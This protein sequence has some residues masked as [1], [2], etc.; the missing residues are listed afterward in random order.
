MPR[1]EHAEHTFTAAPESVAAARS[2]TTRTLESWDLT[3]R[4]D[5]IRLCV[6]EL[7]ANAVEH[8]TRRTA[9]GQG[10]FLVRID[11]DD[12]HIRLEVEDDDPLGTPRLNRAQ[13]EDTGGRGMMIV[14]SLATAWGFESCAFAG[15]AVWSE[16]L[17]GPTADRQDTHRCADHCHRR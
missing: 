15:K 4:A 5:D 10:A 2:F 11:A 16:F 8:G 14:A 12:T 3:R 7:A 17:T 6:S 13:D 9:E 1:H